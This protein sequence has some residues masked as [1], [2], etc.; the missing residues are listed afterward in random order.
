MILPP[1]FR[2][3]RK[4]PGRAGWLAVFFA[5]MAMTVSAQSD[6]MD[7]FGGDPDKYSFLWIPPDTPDWTRHFRIGAIVG[8]NISANFSINGNI[9][10]SGNKA[11]A[12]N[13]D[14]GYVHPGNFTIG[15][16]T[17]TPAWGYTS[18]SQYNPT[19][20]TDGLGS[21]AMH[22]LTSFTT[23]GSSKA[24]G[25]PFPGFDMA[26][27]DNLWY[28]K[29]AR[30][31]WE[32]GFTL[33]PV[34]IK[35]NSSMSATVYQTTY[36]FNTG[37]IDV[38]QA[39][40]SGSSGGQAPTISDSPNLPNSTKQYDH[41]M[42]TG[43]QQLDVMVYTLRLGPNFYWDLNDYLGLSLGAGPAVGL[44]S[45]SYKYNEMITVGGIPTPNN[46]EFNSTKVTYG[47]YA[48]GTLLYHVID[49]ADFYLSA[50]YMPMGS[51]TFSNAGREG[52]LNLGGQIYV[53]L[54]INWPF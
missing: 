15:N 2:F 25:G 54:G 48:D 19:G 52:K 14:D 6:S 11:A 28:W 44:V 16:T 17:Y 1:S 8:M 9:K 4:P 33:L 31:G 45:G 26:Y 13:F 35:D 34:T 10:I 18:A 50:Q 30:V 38:P 27:G 20:G 43:T 47:G 49:D 36:T 12:G 3:A 5:C 51:T 32:V 42:I 46:G 37:G 41:E 29:H 39:P 24:D 40:Y 22:S 21:I 7:T 53:S 23:A